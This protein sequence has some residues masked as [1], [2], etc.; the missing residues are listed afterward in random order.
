MGNGKNQSN[1][2]TYLNYLGKKYL[3]HIIDDDFPL[4]EQ[5]IIGLPFFKKFDRYS[6][7]MP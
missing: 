3:F 6:R 7:T 1:S 5:V 4:P 2:A